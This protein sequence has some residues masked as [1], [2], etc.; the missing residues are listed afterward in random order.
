MKRFPTFIVVIFIVPFSLLFAQTETDDDAQTR[1]SKT[2]FKWLE[3]GQT[4]RIPTLFHFPPSDSQD[5]VT[6]DTKYVVAAIDAFLREFGDISNKKLVTY[7]IPSQ[8]FRIH[9]G[10]IEYW[11]S[12]LD[13]ERLTYSVTFSKAGEGYILLDLCNISSKWQIGFLRFALTLAN[14]K[15]GDMFGEIGKIMWELKQE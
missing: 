3:K 13:F 8:D 15:S 12:H 5:Q 14:D 4:E 10:N 2:F 6:K 9:T 7:Q 1:I 11:Q